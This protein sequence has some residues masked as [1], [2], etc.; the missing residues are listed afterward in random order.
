MLKAVEA[1]R[2]FA[3]LGIGRDQFNEA[4]DAIE[5]EI[6]ERYTLLPVD[7]NGESIC[8]GD[9]LHD[10]I[11]N[12]CVSVIAVGNGCAFYC[13][14]N[15]NFRK[16]FTSNCRHVKQRTIEDVLIDFAAKIHEPQVGSYELRAEEYAPKYAE[17]LRSILKG[18]E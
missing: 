4:L 5:R 16:V 17:E 12:S 7:A 11:S 13:D 3:P 6:S 10:S 1:M 14:D 8:V 18:E 15:A 9:E 2:S